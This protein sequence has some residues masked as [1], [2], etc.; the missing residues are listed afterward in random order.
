MSRASRTFHQNKV[1]KHLRS[2]GFQLM[3][4]WNH[5]TNIPPEQEQTD[6]KQ[7]RRVLQFI[8]VMIS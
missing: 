5:V 8:R 6:F 4:W 7:L 3:F 2:I 1:A